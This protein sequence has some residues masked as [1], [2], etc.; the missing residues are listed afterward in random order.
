MTARDELREAV[1]RALYG[2]EVVPDAWLKAD[3][4]TRVMYRR[5]ADAA[6]REAIP[7]IERETREAAAKVA[8]ESIAPSA[9]LEDDE[10][11]EWG[12]TRKIA[13]MIAAAAI[14]NQEPSR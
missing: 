2:R 11:T 10:L 13:A 14:R 12:R 6:L 5:L 7:R 1:A 9:D 4:D 3:A 8:Y